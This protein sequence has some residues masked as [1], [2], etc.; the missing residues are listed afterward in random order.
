MLKLIQGIRLPYY[1]LDIKNKTITIVTIAIN[2]IIKNVFVFI[3]DN[4]LA[5]ITCG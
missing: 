1:F 4:G 3:F 5:S 2:P